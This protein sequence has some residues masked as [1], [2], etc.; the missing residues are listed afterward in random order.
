MKSIQIIIVTLFFILNTVESFCDTAQEQFLPGIELG[1]REEYDQ[2]LFFFSHYA[3]ENPKDPAAHFF[4]AT[5]WQSRLMDFETNTWEDS[6]LVEIEKTIHLAE[7]ILANQPDNLDYQ[8]YY[9]SALAYKSFQISRQG[10]YIKGLQLGLQAVERLNDIIATDSTYYNAH[11]GIGS[12]LYW[13]SYLTRN[14]NWLPFFRDQREKGIELIQTSFDYGTISK[15][16]ALSN[17][18]WIYIKEERFEDAIRCAERG[19][20]SFPNS[21]FFLWPLGDAL[22]HHKEFE[23]ALQIY[24]QILQSV[25]SEEFNNR[26]NETVLNLK[27]ATCYYEISNW[28]KS[29]WYAERVLTIPPADEVKK[30]LEEKYKKARSLLSEVIKHS[31][32]NDVSSTE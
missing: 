28:E 3:R 17:L 23:K 14:F 27:I 24:E 15:W 4:L 8:F 12:Y 30:R 20:Y 13:R 21:R 9:A 16:A 10:K 25:V 11:L 6:F 22:F 26:Y 7:L 2:A 1:I 19:L 32:K 31:E 5:I 29:A 18:A